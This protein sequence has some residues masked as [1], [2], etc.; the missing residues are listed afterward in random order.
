MTTWTSEKRRDTL[1]DVRWKDIPC[2]R[3]NP[4]LPAFPALGSWDAWMKI[5]AQAP[6]FNDI[7]VTMDHVSGCVWNPS[8][9]I[10]TPKTISKFP[11]MKPFTEKGGPSLGSTSS[12]D[13]HKRC[14]GSSRPPQCPPTQNLR[15]ISEGL[16]FWGLA[17]G[18]RVYH[19]RSESVGDPAIRGNTCPIGGRV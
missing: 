19:A 7:H 5:G 2:L 15:I 4:L 12:F 8:K 3:V 13:P 14:G 9:K 1:L 17:E 16:V 6:S 10:R 11:Q 18:G